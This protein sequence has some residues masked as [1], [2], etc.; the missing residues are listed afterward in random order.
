MMEQKNYKKKFHLVLKSGNVVRYPE[1]NASSQTDSKH[2]EGD[3]NN[4]AI[5]CQKQIL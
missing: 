2:V 5:F 1:A 4:N 3:Q